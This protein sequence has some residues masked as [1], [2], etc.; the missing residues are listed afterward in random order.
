MC[1]TQYSSA[2]H[3][4]NVFFWTGYWNESQ[5]DKTSPGIVGTWDGF[6]LYLGNDSQEAAGLPLSSSLLLG[7]RRDVTRCSSL[8]S[9]IKENPSLLIYFKQDVPFLDWA[10]HERWEYIVL[11]CKQTYATGLL[12]KEVIGPDNWRTGL[13][14]VTRCSDFSVC[15]F[16]RRS[17][18]CLR[19][20]S[21]L[22]E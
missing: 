8:Q 4:V 15:W 6:C 10:C 21:S 19:I 13:P 2:L 5:R 12:R 1:S 7:F 16:F 17:E 14:L 20:G 18:L 11:S 3:T 22:W 9:L